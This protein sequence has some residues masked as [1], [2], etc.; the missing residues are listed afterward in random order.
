[1]AYRVAF[2]FPLILAWVEIL[3]LIK[4]YNNTK[5]YQMVKYI[6]TIFSLKSNMVF[7]FGL[8]FSAIFTVRDFS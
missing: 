7:N 1:V 2:F 4:Y 3:A 8:G 6:R 5:Q